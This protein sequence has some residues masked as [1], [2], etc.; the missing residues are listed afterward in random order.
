MVD[1][2]SLGPAGRMVRCARCKTAWLAGCG[3]DPAQN[4]PAVS[5]FVEG[6]IAEAEARDGKPSGKP[7]LP[8]APMLPATPAPTSDDDFGAEPAHPVGLPSTDPVTPPAA[9]DERHVNIGTVSD[10]PS[11]VPPQSHEPLGGRAATAFEHDEQADLEGFAAR[12]ARMQAKRTRARRSSKWTA[13]ILLLAGFNVALIG[14]R[15]EVVRY[16]PQTASLFA[17]IGLPVNL[18]DLTFENVKIAKEE[19]DGVTVLVVTGTIHSIS[20][21]PVEVPRLRFAVRNATGQEIY[22]W[23]AQ[24]PRSLL[25]GG[26]SVAFRS[27][28]ASPPAD[29]KDVLVRFFSSR[30]ALPG[31]KESANKPAGAKD[32][33][34]KEPAAK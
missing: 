2:G 17:T 9:A 16:L 18:R 15:N 28:L 14:A 27:R 5:N 3:K 22:S 30:D 12:R 33:K 20:S 25:G 32:A 34:T 26:E 4:Q 29:A 10:A 24:P 23:T 7:S 21:R 6:V 13:V 31:E 1:P 8:P 19:H 11:L